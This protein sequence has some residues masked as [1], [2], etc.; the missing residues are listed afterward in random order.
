ME[1]KTNTTTEPPKNKKNGKRN[2][3]IL[4][5]M[6]LL[7]V[8]LFIAQ[9]QLNKVKQ[10]A[11]EDQRLS[12]L[13]IR[14]KQI[15]DSLRL[16]EQAKKDSLKAIEDARIADSLRIADSIRVADSLRTADSLRIADSLA[17]LK[18]INKDSLRAA[19]DSIR[20]ARKARKDSLAR[21]A[22]SLAKYEKARQDSLNKLRQADSL[23]NSDKVPPTA[24]I[25]PPAGRYYSPI[26]LKVKCDEIK[27]KTFISIGD[28]LNPQDASKGIDYNKTGSV[29]F[30]AADSVGN[31]TAWEEANYDM[32]S[33]NV[34]GKN[35]YPVPV[36]GRTVC[37]DAYEYPNQPD[38]T[39]KDMVSQEEAANICK[40]EG[41]HLCSIEEWQAACRGKDNFKYSYGNSYKQNKCNTNTK[42]A[43]R[44]GRKTQC[45]S[46]YGM[47]D[48]NGN[49]WEWTSSTSKQHPDKFLVAGG[50][51]NTNN[52][53]RCT[54][55]K[56]S[57]Y[58]QNQYPSVGFRCCK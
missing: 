17:S 30:Y 14:Q 28:T 58:P 51:W 15:L 12:E 25:T 3:V 10:Q 47:Y 31:R 50:A 36:G 1:N 6:F 38:A 7:L 45:R 55:S 53:S 34:C 18:P 48:M 54:E 21:V 2:L 44:S 4:I 29:F 19:R 40:K 33:D 16:V 20:A 41:K 56:F 11:I 27:C 35:A 24:E 22:D 5:L 23:R 8:C 9:C 52:E 46:W 49:L 32:A 57:F 37:V 13:A 43:K 26:K 39:P 42:S